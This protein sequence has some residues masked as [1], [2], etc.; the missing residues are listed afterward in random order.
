MAQTRYA[1]RQMIDYFD[2]YLG[3]DPKSPN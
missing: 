2:R 1:Y 3:A